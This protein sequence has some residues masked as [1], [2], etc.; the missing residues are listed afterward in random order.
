MMKFLE[1]EKVYLEKLEEEER[2]KAE[3]AEQA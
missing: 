1:D 3:Q 2:K